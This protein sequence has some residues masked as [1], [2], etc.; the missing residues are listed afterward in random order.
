MNVS[1]TPQLENY[2][3][4]RVQEGRYG[5]ASE[6]VRDGLRLLMD[7]EQERTERLAALRQEVQRGADEIG[8]GETV[9]AEEAFAEAQ[10]IIDAATRGKT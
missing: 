1:L 3:K 4:E 8:R 9:S 7:R 6:V 10:N 2:V 5:S